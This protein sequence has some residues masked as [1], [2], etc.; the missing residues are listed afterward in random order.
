MTPVKNKK[1]Y[2]AALISLGSKS[3]QWTIDAMKKYFEKVADISLKHIEINFSGESAQI[4]YKGEPLPKYDCIYAKGSFRYAPLLQGLTA[5]R[6]KKCYMP[7]ESSAFSIVHDK[8]LTQ[9]ALQQ[10]NIPMPRTYQAAT[11]EAAKSIM[12]NMNFPI[13][14]KFPQGTGGKGVVFA[15]SYATASSVL[16]AFTALRQPFIIQEYIET[17]GTDIRAIVVGDKVVAAMQR[18][19]DITEKR[20]NTHSGGKGEPIVLDEYTKKLAV[21]VAKAIKTEVCGVDILKGVKGPLVIEGN[22]SPGLQGITGATK[23][24]VADAIAKYLYER[25]AGIKEE[26][27]EE[28]AAKVMSDAGL[29]GNDTLITTLDFRG[30]RVLLPEL[31]VKKANLEEEADYVITSTPGHLNIKKFEMNGKE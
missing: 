30:A 2:S 1:K 11:A 15:E 4:L 27:Q 18:R 3:S 26:D 17:G 12:K 25:T 8:L 29:D 7:I 10:H 9:L 21:K 20:A 23:I 5:L 6:E 14:M 16:D 31:I 24:D 28:K 19:A 13:I 22:V